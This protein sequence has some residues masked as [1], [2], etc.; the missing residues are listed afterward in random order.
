[1]GCKAGVLAQR[2]TSSV[3]R[4]HTGQR[5]TRA[6]RIGLTVPPTSH[7]TARPVAGLPHSLRNRQIQ[8]A[9]HR[10]PAAHALAR[11][12]CFLPDLAGLAGLRRA[13]P[14]PDRGNSIIFRLTLFAPGGSFRVTVNGWFRT[15]C[16]GLEPRAARRWNGLSFSRAIAKND[17]LMASS[18]SSADV[19]GER[20]GGSRRDDQ[21]LLR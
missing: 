18:D 5:S 10:L 20:I 3:C 1:M 6:G 17:S 2:V 4:E 7:T 19:P 8:K 14:M 21:Q 16:H 9:G 15:E 11:Y 12:R 13:G